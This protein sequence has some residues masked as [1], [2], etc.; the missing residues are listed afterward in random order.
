MLYTARHN[1]S[2]RG[3]YD[4]TEDKALTLCTYSLG[5]VWP[6]SIVSVTIVKSQSELHANQYYWCHSLFTSA[7]PGME[8]S[9]FGHPNPS[10]KAWILMLDL[11]YLEVRSSYYIPFCE[12]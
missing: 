4:I 6:A 3:T 1:R 12:A 5:A 8:I 9:A 7:M 2:N 11:W 10:A